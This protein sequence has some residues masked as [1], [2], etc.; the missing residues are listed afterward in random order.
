MHGRQLRRLARRAPH[1]Q[2][3]LSRHRGSSGRELCRH[4]TCEHRRPG[5][6]ETVTSQ[7]VYEMGD[8]ARYITPDCIADFTSIQ[9]EQE[10]EARVRVSGVKALRPRTPTR[11][12]SPT[13]T[14]TRSWVN[15]RW[16][17]PMPSKRPSCARYRLRA[18]CD[19]RRRNSPSQRL[20]EFVGTNVCHA[21]IAA[22]PEEPA[23]VVLRIGAKGTTKRR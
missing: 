9:L 20:V 3:R 12:R 18:R 7:L 15:S 11:S 16:P 13:W 21:G 8:P 17:V 22:A 1:G 5:H 14:G 23:E 2:D 19:G 6:T 4:Q 10:A